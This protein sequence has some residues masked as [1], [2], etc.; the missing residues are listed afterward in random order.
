MTTLHFTKRAILDDIRR[1]NSSNNGNPRYEL[2]F[3]GLGITGKTQSDSA[4]A[5]KIC[6]YWQGRPVEVT[7]KIT[8]AGNVT[9]TNL[10]ELK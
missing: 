4:F 8:R 5:Y 7:F 10:E 6:D 9:I 3:D 2:T 1:I